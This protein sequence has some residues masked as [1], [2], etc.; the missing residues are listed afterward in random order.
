MRLKDKVALITGAAS[1]I[2]KA[3]AELFAREGALII[4]ADAAVEAGNET[5]ACIQKRGGHASFSRVDVSNSQQVAQIVDGAIEAFGR[6]DILFNGAAILAYGTVVE[7]DE[8]MWNR[9]ITIN[10]TGTFLC[11]RAVVPHMI[12]QGGGSIINVAS[13]TGAHDASARAVAYVTSKGGVTLFTRALAID[14][15]HQGIRVNALCPGPT[16]TPMLR[17]AMTPEQLEQFAK[18]YPMGRLARPEELANAAL[19]LASDES[20]FVTG[21]AMYVDGG[22]TA[23][24]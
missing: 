16:D 10:L 22:Q 3:T 11:C 2:A 6:I 15:A 17:N 23:K 9:M 19:F 7:T 18:T 8:A 12:R 24:I 5:V 21:S 20:S 14:H 1:G 13:T 4:A